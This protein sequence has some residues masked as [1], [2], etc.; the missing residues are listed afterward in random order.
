M[1]DLIYLTLL[2]KG[3]IMS[4]S[5]AIHPLVP[6]ILNG[7]RF[8]SSEIFIPLLDFVVIKEYN[9]SSH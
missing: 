7:K 5:K 4:S 9:D 6:C 1:N 2:L 3:S 8:P